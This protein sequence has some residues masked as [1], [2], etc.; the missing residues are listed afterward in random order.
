MDKAVALKTNSFW[1]LL[2]VLTFVNALMNFIAFAFGDVLL[3]KSTKTDLNV[4][5]QLGKLLVSVNPSL[6]SN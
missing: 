2:H 4:F 6:F 1:V 3:V 5:F